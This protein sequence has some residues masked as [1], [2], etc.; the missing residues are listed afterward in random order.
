MIEFLVFVITVMGYRWFFPRSF[1]QDKGTQIEIIQIHR[2]IQTE[3]E[4]SMSIDLS[5]MD[6]DDTFFS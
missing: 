4:D 3:D 1:K 6:I 5:D 2:G